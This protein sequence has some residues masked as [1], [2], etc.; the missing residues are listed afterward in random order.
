MPLQVFSGS[1]ADWLLTNLWS[2]ITCMEGT[3]AWI[4]NL[5]AS[6]MDTHQYSFDKMLEPTRQLFIP[7]SSSNGS[8]KMTRLPHRSCFLR[9]TVVLVIAMGLISARIGRAQDLSLL[10]V[11]QRMLESQEQIDSIS[12]QYRVHLNGGQF[13]LRTIAA[14]APCFLF[15]D[16]SHGGPK[17]DPALDINRQM[18]YVLEDRWITYRPLSR[19]IVSRSLQR[20]H[21]VPGSMSEELFFIATAVWPLRSRETPKPLG[22]AHFLLDIASSEDFTLHDQTEEI[23][24]RS[25]HLLIHKTGR[26]HLWI[27]IARGC[28][29]VRREFYDQDGTSLLSRLQMTQHRK[30]AAGV[31]LPFKIH[32]TDFD[33]RVTQQFGE[34]PR[35]IDILAELDYAHVNTVSDDRFHFLAPPGTLELDPEGGSGEPRQIVAGGIDLLVDQAKW[36][37]QCAKRQKNDDSSR[38]FWDIAIVLF[39]LVVV[40]YL[41]PFAVS[42]ASPTGRGQI[43]QETGNKGETK[44][45]KGVGSL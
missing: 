9:M 11:K 44:G 4:T 29:I 22:H 19:T 41:R 5:S 3:A 33:T 6:N 45:N 14:K 1:A 38:V 40:V 25:C 2:S 32:R 12:V 17:N 18:T 7:F 20:S 26:D 15:H 28:C 39:A 30:V 23:A 35:V 42:V 13:L 34:Q 31:W 36:I 16:S 10:E 27:D 21:G 37:G 43:L 24:G 8:T